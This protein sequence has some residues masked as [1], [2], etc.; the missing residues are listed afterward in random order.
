MKLHLG[1][2]RDKK[3][4]YVNCDISKDV[5]IIDDDTFNAYTKSQKSS[6]FKDF[7]LTR[8]AS[9][10]VGNN[11]IEMFGNPHSTRTSENTGHRQSFPG[12]ARGESR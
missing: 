5:K 2:G 7:I 6:V 11:Y 4:G 9:A 8:G 3:N 1:C 10:D 12:V